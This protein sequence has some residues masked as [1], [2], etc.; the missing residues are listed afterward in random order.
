MVNFEL[1]VDL[2]RFQTNWDADISFR[3]VGKC[4]L[5]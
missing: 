1:G 2:G 4:F 3:V 5:F